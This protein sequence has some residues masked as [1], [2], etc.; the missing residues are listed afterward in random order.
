MKD[1]AKTVFNILGFQYKP[2]EK[3][4]LAQLK[5]WGR[6]DLIEKYNKCSYARKIAILDGMYG[7]FYSK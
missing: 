3:K 5:E 7:K 2:L 1:P 6:Q 4:V